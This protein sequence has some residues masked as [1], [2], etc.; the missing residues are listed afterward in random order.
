VGGK[1]DVWGQP[2]NFAII[3]RDYRQR[4]PRRIDPWNLFFRFRFS[5]ESK[6]GTGFDGRGL[7][8]GPAGSYTDISRQTALSTGI[9]YYHRRDHWREP[10]NLLN[11]YW[12]ATLVPA[13]VDK[14]GSD[15]LKDELR[16][17]GVGWAADTYSALE[18]Q[19]FKGAP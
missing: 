13:T 10:P 6:P 19:G 2:K 1:D 9:A 16:G 15:D 7:Q 5:G 17:A 4:D 12:R 3:Q 14:T 18:R 11:P 8:L